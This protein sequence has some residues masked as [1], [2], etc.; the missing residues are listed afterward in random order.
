MF[1]PFRTMRPWKNSTKIIK[2]P[3][4]SLGER[5]AP[6][7][8]PERHHR[9]E[10]L[11]LLF[12]C[13]PTPPKF[14]G[15]HF[16]PLNLGGGPQKRLQNKGFRAL[17]PQNLGGDMAPPK[18]RGYG[19]AGFAESPILYRCLFTETPQSKS[20]HCRALQSCYISSSKTFWSAAVTLV[21]QAIW[22]PLSRYTLSRRDNALRF[23]YGT[24]YHVMPPNK[25]LSYPF[26]LI[27]GVGIA[28]L[29]VLRKVSRYTPVSQL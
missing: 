18:F 26:C 20:Y 7:F 16:H 1:D 27:A 25:A 28:G 14:W 2:T 9:M 19:L 10:D 5:R 24:P 22:F 17:H 21:A 23:M 13:Q 4:H 8:R 12:P 15:W 6:K 3:R 11:A 29:A